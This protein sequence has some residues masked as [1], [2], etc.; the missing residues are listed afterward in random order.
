[1][2]VKEQVEKKLADFAFK[3]NGERE[4]WINN[5]NKNNGNIIF[6]IN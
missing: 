3:N 6:E 2:D 1:M 4:K 5:W